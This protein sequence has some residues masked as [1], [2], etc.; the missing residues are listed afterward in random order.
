MVE[1]L[2]QKGVHAFVDE[3]RNLLIERRRDVGRERVGHRRRTFPGRAEGADD[4]DV[5]AVRGGFPGETYRRAVHVLD[6][7]GE[8]VPGEQ[9]AIRRIRVGFE[10]IR[11]RADVGRMDRLHHVGGD[12][13]GFV[14][15]PIDGVPTLIKLGPHRPVGDERALPQGFEE[16]GSSGR[17]FAISACIITPGSWTGRRSASIR[18]VPRAGGRIVA[19]RMRETST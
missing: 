17:A 13:I 18:A 14:E 12:E 10:Q 11:A 16:T 7:V 3:N 8:S 2:E 1:G 6:P 15:R 9:E 19:F 5:D 4:E